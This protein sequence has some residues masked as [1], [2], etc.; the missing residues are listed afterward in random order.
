[1]YNKTNVKNK[2]FYKKDLAILVS[3]E[4]AIILGSLFFT[5]N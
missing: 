2:N 5:M 1:M 4:V 3:F